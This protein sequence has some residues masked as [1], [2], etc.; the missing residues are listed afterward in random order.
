MPA[1]RGE[2]CLTTVSAS[3]SDRDTIRSVPPLDEPVRDDELLKFS[4]LDSLGPSERAQLTTHLSRQAYTAGER[5]VEEGNVEDRM[6]FI[7]AGEATIE[8][9]GVMIAP[10]R[11]GDHFGELGLVGGIER[12]ASVVA[13]TSLEVATLEKT[14]LDALTDA[15]PR[16]ALLLERTL[17]RRTSDKLATLA[18][19]VG[20]LLNERSLPR[21]LTVSIRVG[22][23]LHDVPM[24]TAV[25]ELMPRRVDD[26]LVVGALVDHRSKSLT[27]RL[28]ANA[29]IAPLTT[30]HWEGQ[31]IYQR[32]LGL[33]L[34]EAGRAV[35]PDLPIRIGHSVGLG[36]RVH[37]LAELDR[38]RATLARELTLAMRRL[39]EDDAQLREEWWMV[40]EAQGHLRQAG[41]E[42]AAKLLD[43][44]YDPAVQLVSYG[45]VHALRPAPFLPSTAM[46]RHFDVIADEH[47]LL[48]VF[49]AEAAKTGTFS[50]WP[51]QKEVQSEVRIAA[52]QTGEM[53]AHHARWLDNLGIDS[54]GSF[55]AACVNGDVSQLIR[56]AEGF[57]EKQ[58]SA[59]ADAIHER[60]SDVRVICV[61]G[62]SSSGKTTFIQRLSVQLQVNGITPVGLGL[63]DY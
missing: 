45:A 63:D 56:V 4:V 37:V 7:L 38:D 19:D 48:L 21:R 49:G 20:D 9:G 10:V 55:N 60:G 59:I 32:S 5:V 57:Q 24:G 30:A 33:L 14:E 28:S 34:L 58:L 31:R 6:H 26:Q 22:Q 51:G 1:P 18:N 41:W 15:S 43:S 47:G 36:Q 2:R 52:K 25:R 3:I 23:S 16:I 13:R 27:H 11:V 29:S 40:N 62:P 46:M 8:T 35:A 61:A 17:L 44:H 12:Q 54:V 50:A 42:G 39:T 53:I